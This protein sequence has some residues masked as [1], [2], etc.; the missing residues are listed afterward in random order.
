MIFFY[1]DL[2]VEGDVGSIQLENYSLMGN[3][4]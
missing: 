1:I 4:G 3:L 2:N